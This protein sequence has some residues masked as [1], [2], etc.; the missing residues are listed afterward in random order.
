M[1]KFLFSLF[2]LI[3]SATAFAQSKKMVATSNGKIVGVYVG[4]NA[5]S[6][7]VKGDENFEVPIEGHKIVTF[8]AEKGEGYISCKNQGTVNVRSTP[9]ASGAKIG[10]IENYPGEM[11]DILRCLGKTKGWYKVRFG[12]KIGY[13]RQDLVDWD[14]FECD[15]L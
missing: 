1:K 2:A 8:S 9:S 7:T 3:V 11:P 4:T 6:Y 12:K 14:W 13:V 10:K 5:S 15:W